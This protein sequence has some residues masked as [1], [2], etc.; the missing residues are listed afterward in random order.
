M[1]ANK[2]P[3]FF[4]LLV[5]HF[6][7]A[8]MALCQESSSDNLQK[9]G[10]QMEVT[11]EAS[12]KMAAVR[13][14][15]F[16][17]PESPRITASC[18]KEGA[19]SVVLGSSVRADNILTYR[20]IEP[21]SYSLSVLNGSIIPDATGH[22]PSGNRPLASS[23]KFNLKAGSFT[24]FVVRESGGKYTIDPYRDEVVTDA[25]GPNLR[26]LNFSGADH[27]GIYLPS[28]NKEREIWNSQ[29]ST[30]FFLKG[31]K[32]SNPYRLQLCRIVDGNPERVS[33]FETEMSSQSAC[34]VVIYLDRY[35][36]LAMRV[37]EDGKM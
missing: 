23:P 2:P 13:L 5:V 27:L 31:L 33:G 30:P 37:V 10:E 29:A 11:D 36:D 26:I 34:S 4:C 3:F 15:Y 17:S 28:E 24:T 9:E 32:G 1:S 20:E 7:L 25:S 18:E 35:G 12:K 19:E 21:G 8:Q 22:I 16:G 14:W 6:M